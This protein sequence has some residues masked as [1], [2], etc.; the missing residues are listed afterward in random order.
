MTGGVGTLLFTAPEI[1][2]GSRYRQ[3]ADVWS[4]GC[5]MVCLG[6]QRPRPY[7]EEY[8]GPTLAV[9]MARADGMIKPSLPEGVLLAGLVDEC[10]VCEPAGRCSIERALVLLIELRDR[11]TEAE[12]SSTSGSSLTS[13]SPLGSL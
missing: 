7:S 1:V 9:R 4:F 8:L 3:V 5:L 6:S 10:C 12:L 13:N 2:R 11:E